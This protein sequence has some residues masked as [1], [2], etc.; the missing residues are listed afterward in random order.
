MCE[1]ILSVFTVQLIFLS[2]KVHLRIMMR[3]KRK[4]YFRV[5]C[6]VVHHVALTSAHGIE[7]AKP[8]SVI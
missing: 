7:L 8:H 6:V 1:A 2:Q 4:V 3:L 5:N